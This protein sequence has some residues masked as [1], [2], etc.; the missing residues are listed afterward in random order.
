MLF[1]DIHDFFSPTHIVII[2]LFFLV[3]A[4][5]FCF[6]I[7]SYLFLNHYTADFFVFSTDHGTQLQATAYDY[8]KLVFISHY[9]LSSD[10]AQ[11]A[12]PVNS[13]GTSVVYIA[14]VTYR[15]TI[16]TIGMSYLSKKVLSKEG[17]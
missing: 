9:H 7:P 8:S 2:F 11:Q 4:S 6:Q 12:L 5:H 16:L 10:F 15:V 13:P 3:K 1:P 14:K 17:I